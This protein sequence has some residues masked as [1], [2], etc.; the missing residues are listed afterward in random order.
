MNKIKIPA[1]VPQIQNPLDFGIGLAL[2]Q[3]SEMRVLCKYMEQ[4]NFPLQVD[5]TYTDCTECHDFS[6][7]D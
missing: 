3:E 2:S 1:N 6:D 5:Y 4:D 7:S